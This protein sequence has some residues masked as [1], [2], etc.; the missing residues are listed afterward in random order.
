[1][2][3]PTFKVFFLFIALIMSSCASAGSMMEVEKRIDI[4]AEQQDDLVS[5]LKTELGKLAKQLK[6]LDEISN[7]QQSFTVSQQQTAL[8]LDRA[9]KNEA[10]IKND[11]EK[12]YAKFE[13]V[14]GKQE[15]KKH[16]ASKLAGNVKSLEKRITRVRHTVM[17]ANL[18]HSQKLESMHEELNRSIAA[19]Y[20]KLAVLSAAVPEGKPAEE[21]K[22]EK[23]PEKIKEI[24]KPKKLPSLISADELYNK[25]YNS[26]L[27]GNY[28]QSE[29]EFADYVKRYPN[30][31]LSDN[32][33]YWLGE[34]LANQ[35]KLK[36]AA[37]A[38]ALTADKYPGSSKA[39]SALWRA[40]QLWEKQKNKKLMLKTLR[41]IRDNYP[42]SY[43]SSLAREKLDSIK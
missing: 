27:A 29:A 14:M 19:I 15:E 38:F 23:A 2:K 9:L 34:A 22:K 32:S 30:T 26:F 18:A 11:L 3:L 7:K 5:D 35:G 16:Y 10:D 31:D 24:V 40:A 43:E 4:V 33:Q 37:R 20:E 6:Q 21:L 13:N 28:V 12:L 42:S 8:V 1:M 39:P 25:A 41:K 17:E 36:E